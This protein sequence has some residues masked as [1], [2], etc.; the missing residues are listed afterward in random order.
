MTGVAGPR[1]LYHLWISL[2]CF[3]E[4]VNWGTQVC[5]CSS[6]NSWDSRT[7][8]EIILWIYQPIYLAHESSSFTL[9]II[10]IYLFKFIEKIDSNSIMSMKVIKMKLR[11]IKSRLPVCWGEHD[12][13]LSPAGKDVLVM[14]I[15]HLQ[16]LEYNQTEQTWEMKSSFKRMY[17]THSLAT[18]VN[19]IG[20]VRLI[21]WGICVAELLPILNANSQYTQMHIQIKCSIHITNNAIQTCTICN[22]RS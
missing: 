17:L 20:Y 15:W 14:H 18:S 3:T 1:W 5:K 11:D 12:I 6:I 16:S 13:C 21:L 19:L 4:F 22:I 2:T 9:K 10:K 7:H 8:K